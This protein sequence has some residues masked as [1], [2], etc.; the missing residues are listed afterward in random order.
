MIVFHA[1]VGFQMALTAL[2]TSTANSNSVPVYDSGE[3]SKDIF[4]S[5]TV[6]TKSRQIW[7]ALV[8]IFLMPALSKPNTTRRCSVDVELYKWTMACFEPLMDSKVRLISASRACVKTWMMTSSGIK[9][10]SIIFRTKS[11]SVCEA[12]GKPTS[13]SL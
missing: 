13:I 5:G 10:S 11:K 4:V 12:L 9:F 1:G 2:Q 3:Y 7:A 6:G 8:A